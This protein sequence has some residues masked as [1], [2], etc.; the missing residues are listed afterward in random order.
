MN[1]TI[2]IIATVKTKEKQWLSQMVKR[3]CYGIVHCKFS[4]DKPKKQSI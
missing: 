2:I 1:V 3:V 4:T